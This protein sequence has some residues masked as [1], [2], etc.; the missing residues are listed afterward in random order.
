MNFIKLM[1]F[2]SEGSKNTGRSLVFRHANLLTIT[3]MGTI[4]YDK[5]TL[6]CNKEK[7]TLQKFTSNYNFCCKIDGK[8]ISLGYLEQ[9]CVLLCPTKALNLII[10]LSFINGLLLYFDLYKV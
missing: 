4:D 10:I 7:D 1:V 2:V 9:L 6:P 5:K 3:T 8:N